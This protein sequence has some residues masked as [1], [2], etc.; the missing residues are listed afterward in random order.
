VVKE[1]F[2]KNGINAVTFF[3]QNSL[4]FLSLVLVALLLADTTA[5]AQLAEV[6][7]VAEFDNTV[8]SG[9]SVPELSGRGEHFGALSSWSKLGDNHSVADQLAAARSA[10]ALG[11]VAKARSL[12]EN[13]LA[14]EEFQ[15]PE[16]ARTVLARAILELQEKQYEKARAISERA[17]REFE[18]SPL[19]AQF[20]LVIAEALK[21]QGALSL[22]ED[23]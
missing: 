22:A 3:K 4:G 15:G 13:V 7:P 20:W 16:R 2:S 11:L 23:Y 9:E 1:V 5:F 12:W 8:P 18:R 19:R 14:N 21:G 10:W 17:A 6:L